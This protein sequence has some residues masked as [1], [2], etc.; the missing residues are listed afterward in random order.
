MLSL[1]ARGLSVR[2]IQAH[3]EEIYGTQ[4]SP[5]LI[6]TVT[7]AVLD[8]VRAWQCRPLDALYPVVYLDA[9]QV[10]VKSDGRV[11]N[12]AIYLAIGINV[13]G[14]KE[15]LGLWAAQNEG[16]KF[17]LGVVSELKNRGV[18]DIFIACV[19]GLKGFPEAIEAVF[20]Q[21]QVQL[22]LVHLV[23][24]SLAFVSFKDRKE[25][26][27]GL[28]AIYQ[29]VTAGEAEARL[30]EFASQWDAQYPLIAKSWRSNWARLVPMF[31][32]PPE[33][34]RAVYTTNTIESLNMSL[35]KIIKT[36]AS[37]PSDEA[38]FKLLYLA[39]QNI[40]KKWTMPIPNWGRA[41]NALAILFEDRMPNN[42]LN[43]FTQN[44]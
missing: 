15:V 9:L 27:A 24:Y 38:A 19:D 16:A 36:R 42:L 43:S 41:L 26:A 7:D 10:K 33:I 11:Q 44:F 14:H 28:K 21:T 2:E 23:R 22:C 31:G 37:F 4:V 1:Y 35:R 34:R 29:A 40:Q 32:Y 5:D 3:L 18:Q 30:Q 25:V 20:P 39:L 17:W 12:K 8:E 13:Q 6:S